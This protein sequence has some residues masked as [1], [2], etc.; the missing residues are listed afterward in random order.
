MLKIASEGI[1]LSTARDPSLLPLREKVDR[2][3]ATRRTR[4]AGK[5]T[6]FLTDTLPLRPTPLIR[7]RF[8]FARLSHLLPQ[9]EKGEASRTASATPTPIRFADSTGQPGPRCYAASRRSLAFRHATG[10]TNSLRE[11]ASH[12]REGEG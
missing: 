9:G 5:S 4:G 8:R 2:R 11:P 3:A 6:A 10:M 1:V 7:P 12:P